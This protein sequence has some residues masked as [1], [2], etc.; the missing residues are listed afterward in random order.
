MPLEHSRYYKRRQTK[1][2]PKF[3]F[4]QEYWGEVRDPDGKLR[5]LVEERDKRYKDYK[6]EID[7]INKM[8]AGKILDV[9]CGYGYALSW[10]SDKWE[11]HGTELSNHTAKI[12]Q[13]YGKIFV[14]KLEDAKYPDNYFDVITSF[15]VLEHVEDPVIV[16]REMYRILKDDGHLILQIPD[17]DSALARRFKDNYRML[18]DKTHINLFS[19]HGLRLLL[20]DNFFQ[21]DRVEFPYFESVHFTKENL[22]RL[23]DTSKISPPFYGN[24]MSFYSRKI[25]GGKTTAEE[26]IAKLLRDENAASRELI[27]SNTK[28]LGSL[29]KCLAQESENSSKS[30]FVCEKSNLSL[31]SSL[32]QI[33]DAGWD[34]RSPEQLSQ[35]KDVSTIVLIGSP[36]VVKSGLSSVKSKNSQV[37]V[38]CND[39]KFLD[40]LHG[41]EIIHI[42]SNGSLD[43]LSLSIS[44]LTSLMQ[45]RLRTQDRQA[46]SVS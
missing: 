30:V 3:Q 1:E 33:S 24:V 17:F 9:G 34:W 19:C 41:A 22:E 29:A 40:T 28:S 14:G 16:I 45:F 20:E 27:A 21:I 2:P 42:P 25:G 43:F 15:H 18:H 23:F 7:F 36:E 11:R 37:F 31:Y 32:A 13:K 10:V 8:P 39:R 35:I 46:L 6:D 26:T 44:L 5:N 38:I 12:A 4:E